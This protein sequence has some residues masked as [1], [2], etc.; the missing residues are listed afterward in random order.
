MTDKTPAD[1]VRNNVA[2][3][4]DAKLNSALG[5]ELRGLTWDG[6]EDDDD[7]YQTLIV[8]D[9]DGRRFEIEFEVNVTELTDEVLAGRAAFV[10][11]MKKLQ[12]RHA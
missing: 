11:R 5:Y 7:P 6:D 2:E 3:L 4:L 9:R 1:T 10:E 8:K 12:A